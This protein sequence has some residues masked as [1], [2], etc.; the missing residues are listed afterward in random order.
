MI[1]N[2]IKRGYGQRVNCVILNSLELNL[3]SS[4]GSCI[5]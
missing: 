2:F 3:D 1:V 5:E 4:L